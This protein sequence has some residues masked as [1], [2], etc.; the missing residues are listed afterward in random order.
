[1]LLAGAAVVFLQYG[2]WWLLKIREE[3]WVPSWLATTKSDDATLKPYI[4]DGV[5]WFSLLLLNRNC[6]SS[7]LNPSWTSEPEQGGNH[8]ER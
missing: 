1:M 7:I 8:A 2:D 4:L 6:N 3:G 5:K